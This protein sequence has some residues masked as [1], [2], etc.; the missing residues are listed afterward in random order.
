MPNK[1]IPSGRKSGKVMS[2]AINIQADVAPIG[3]VSGY[4]KRMLP[5]GTLR[6]A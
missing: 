5:T 6:K 2:A 3:Q 4:I 1:I